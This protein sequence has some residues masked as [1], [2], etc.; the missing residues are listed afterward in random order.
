MERATMLFSIPYLVYLSYVWLEQWLLTKV[1]SILESTPEYTDC[2]TFRW[3]VTAANLR[4][5]CTDSSDLKRFNTVL[6]MYC[7]WKKQDDVP[8]PRWGRTLG[9]LYC[10]ACINHPSKDLWQLLEGWFNFVMFDVHGP[11]CV[12]SLFRLL[13][14]SRLIEPLHSFIQCT[15][16]QRCQKDTYA[17]STEYSVH[18]TLSNT[19]PAP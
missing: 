10:C 7:Y 9:P 6:C 4:R 15:Q 1:H 3:S 11:C 14:S 16:D 13:R 17:R 8:R 12:M 2:P 18:A 5:D 19:L